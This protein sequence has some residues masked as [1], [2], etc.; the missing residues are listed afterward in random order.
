M[1]PH[2]EPPLADALHQRTRPGW[3]SGRMEET[4]RKGKGA[5]RYLERAVDKYGETMDF[6]LTEQRAPAAA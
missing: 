2:I 6:L 5:W 4:S 3:S 1:G